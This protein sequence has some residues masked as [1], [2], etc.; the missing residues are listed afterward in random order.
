MTTVKIVVILI[1]FLFSL[2]CDSAYLNRTGCWSNINLEDECEDDTASIQSS[3]LLVHNDRVSNEPSQIN[4]NQRNLAVLQSP[5]LNFVYSVVFNTATRTPISTTYRTERPNGGRPSADN[6]QAH[7]FNLTDEEENLHLG[8]DLD[9]DSDYNLYKQ[10]S[11]RRLDAYYD[12]Q[13]R[14]GDTTNQMYHRGHLVPSGD[15]DQDS[16]QTSTFYYFNA[17]PMWGRLNCVVWKAVE[18]YVRGLPI[19]TVVT[20]GATG[21]MTRMVRN[22]STEIYLHPANYQNSVLPAAIPVPKYVWKRVE[23]TVFVLW[24]D[25]VMPA[26]PNNWQNEFNQNGEICTRFQV[27]CPQEFTPRPEIQCCQ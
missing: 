9:K 27:A 8:Y 12:N 17:V 2:G 3:C 13:L 11:Q 25:H 10:Q 26:F 20:T 15:F 7:F 23:G 14:I 1:N 21:I 22:Q 4:P 19:T 6:W 5:S 18:D 16:K 24:N